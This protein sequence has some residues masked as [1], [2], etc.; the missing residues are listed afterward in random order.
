LPVEIPDARTSTG[1]RLRD[2]LD[3]DKRRGILVSLVTTE[4]E[5][6]EPGRRSLREL[7]D[8]ANREH[9]L[10][11]EAGEAMVEHAIRA[12][13]WLLEAK[14]RCPK[15]TWVRWREDHFAA[16]ITAC[17]I[18]MKMA[19][20][21]E[22]L[23]AREVTSIGQAK[24]ILYASDVPNMNH[25]HRRYPT[26]MAE[27]AKELRAEGR[28]WH[29]IGGELGVAPRTAKAWVDPDAAERHKASVRAC[30]KRKR[31]AEMALR[32]RERNQQIKRAVRKAGAAEQDLYAMAERMQDVMGQAHREATDP[33]KRRHYSLAGE[34]YRKMRD[35]IVRG[36]GVA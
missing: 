32:E 9:A 20:H 29:A 27:A 3:D 2:G 8:A 17:A 16:G 11:V 34:H 23:R 19:H 7:A 6:I 12:G 4:H 21:Q 5:V 24:Q 10:V 14:S 15:G 18:Y 30:N 31:Q 22:M 26:Y 36:L 28:T 35:E 33:E 25:G 1:D 13:A